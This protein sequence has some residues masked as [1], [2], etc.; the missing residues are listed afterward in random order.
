MKSIAIVLALALTACSTVVPVTARFP[1]PPGR[2][3][4]E[5]CPDL[6]KLGDGAQLSDVARTV[7]MNYTTYWTCATKSDAWIE[8]YRVQKHIFEAAGK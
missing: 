4:L 8:W 2:A 5:P 3:A 7:T 6:Q 1:E